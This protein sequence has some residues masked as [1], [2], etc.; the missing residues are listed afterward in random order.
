MATLQQATLDRI[1]EL[2]EADVKYE[3]IGAEVGLSASYVSFLCLKNG[4]E[5]SDPSRWPTWEGIRGPAVMQRGN[6]Q[7][8]R[9]T[10]AEDAQLLALEAEGISLSEIA[11]R[12]GRAR[13]SVQGRLMTLARRDARK[14][15]A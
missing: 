5:P 12:M 6:H 8:R 1:A 11:R 14:E 10:D 4:F 3:A 7:V 13:N 15:A 9:F 2:R